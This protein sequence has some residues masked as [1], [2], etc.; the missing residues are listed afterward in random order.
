MM[1]AVLGY[2]QKNDNVLAA[3][4]SV[5]TYL[6]KGGVFICDRWYGLSV[7]NQKP[8]ERVNVLENRDRKKYP[9]SISEVGYLLAYGEHTFP[10]LEY[11]RGLSTR[12]KIRRSYDGILYPQ[13][14]I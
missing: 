3:L 2:P 12:R 4:K 11:Q 8:R 6:K 1:F 10:S 13:E 5:S 7:L 9:G 14:L